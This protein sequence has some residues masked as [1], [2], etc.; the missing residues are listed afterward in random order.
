MARAHARV[1][2]ARVCVSRTYVCARALLNLLV[3]LHQGAAGAEVVGGVGRPASGWVL[4][5][6]VLCCAV[7]AGGGFTQL[8]FCLNMRLYHS[9]CEHMRMHE[10]SVNVF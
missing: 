7:S 6:A 10:R 4:C 9:G 1:Y 3:C 2:A 8:F 5:C